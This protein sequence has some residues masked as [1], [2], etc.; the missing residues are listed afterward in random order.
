MADVKSGKK[1]VYI[2]QSDGSALIND[3]KERN[4]G[5]PP[6]KFTKKVRGT[7][8]KVATNLPDVNW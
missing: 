8:A 3:K 5:I 2:S 1:K 6:G 4:V 7:K